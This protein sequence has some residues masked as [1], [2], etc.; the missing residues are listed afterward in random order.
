MEDIKP[1]YLSTG[2]WGS[3]VA[4]LAAIAGLAGY[5][6]D[7]QSQH[8]IVLVIVCVVTAV[9]SAYS[10]MG[11]LKATKKIGKQSVLQLTPNMEVKTPPSQQ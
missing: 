7:P 10:L 8:D 11:R 1:W 5:A 6:I 4:K 3:I 2:I 9:S